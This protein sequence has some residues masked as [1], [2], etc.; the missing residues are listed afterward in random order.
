VPLLGFDGGRSQLRSRLRSAVSLVVDRR[1]P[2]DVIRDTLEERGLELA[3]A[4]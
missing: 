2:I 1:Q 3:R 4:A